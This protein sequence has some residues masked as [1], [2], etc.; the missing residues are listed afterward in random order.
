MD[1]LGRYLQEQRIKRGMSLEE[2]AARTRIRAQ[3]LQALE[4]DEYEAL[5]VPVTVR[6]FLRAYAR[7][8]GLDEQAVVA[9]YQAVA[10]DR[11]PAAQD[12]DSI[13]AVVRRGPEPFWRR[14]LTLAGMTIAGLVVA[15]WGVVALKPTAEPEHPMSIAI[16]GRVVPL[17]PAVVDPPISVPELPGAESSADPSATPPG[18]LPPSESLRPAPIDAVQ[19]QKLTISATETSWL[20]VMIDDREVKDVLLQPGE[21]ITW[22]AEH[23]F[24]LTIGNAGGVSVELNGQPLGQLGPSGKVRSLV[25]PRMAMNDRPAPDHNPQATETGHQASHPALT[26]PPESATV[27]TRPSQ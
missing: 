10:A 21:R 25:L 2:L 13:G 7:C 12:A 18:A 16:P 22:A 14:K 5:P 19:N 9:R 3:T 27:P 24:R 8:L 4:Q 26:S 20:H 11:A 17:E 23:G 6:G 1:S 15:I